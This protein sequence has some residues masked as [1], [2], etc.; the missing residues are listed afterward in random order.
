MDST[1]FAA[2]QRSYDAGDFATALAGFSALTADPASLA[3]GELG[4]VDHLIGN[5]LVRLKRPNEAVGAYQA[6]LADE[7]Y[8]R[9]GAVNSNLGMALVSAG[10]YED[11]LAYFNAALSDPTYDSPY[12]AFSG[13]GS[14]LLK[15]GHPADAGIAYR[16]AALDE[17]NPNPGKALMNLGVC[18]MALDRPAD[19]IEAY[20]TALEFETKQ[21]SRNRICANLGQ[22]YVAAGRMV[23]AVTAFEQATADG[24][25]RLS[26]AA[27]ADY[28]RAQSAGVFA[29]QTTSFEAPSDFVGQA[30]NTPVDPAEVESTIPSPDD[31]GFFTITEDQITE[32]DRERMSATRKHRHTGLKVLIVILV[33]LLAAVGAAAYGYLN[34]YGYP[35]SEAVV[36]ELFEKAGTDEVTSVWAPEVD[37]KAITRS[38]MAIEKGSTPQIETVECTPRTTTAHVRATLPEGGQ[39]TYDIELIR[40]GISWKI[41]AVELTHQSVN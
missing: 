26:E 6:A 7:A 33:L 17:G 20:S 3:P 38:M 40:D 9:K 10:R 36:T 13:M 18:F 28:M 37:Q 14:A 23:D 21:Q 8:E 1:A 11:S 16:R 41:A 22:A 25:Y 29:P 35:S 15:L 39:V 12:K 4:Q 19:A 34:G 2:A 32:M 5:C 24:T 31:T 27:Q 30:T